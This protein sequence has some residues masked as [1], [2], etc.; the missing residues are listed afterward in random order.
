MKTRFYYL[1]LPLLGILLPAVVVGIFVNKTRIL[2]HY[3]NDYPF[4]TQILGA[5]EIHTH[6]EEKDSPPAE[7]STPAKKPGGHDHASE[8]EFSYKALQNIGVTKETIQ[9]TTVGEFPLTMNYPASV[10]ERPGRSTTN[11]TTPVSGIVLRIY[12]QPGEI[13]FP[14]EPM[15]DMDLSNESVITQQMDLI[16][17]CQKRDILEQ[18]LKRLGDV[19][20]G[21]V[22][23]T[24]R[25]TEFEKRQVE[26]GIQSLVNTLTLSGF[27]EE[28]IRRKI[29]D[30]RT[31]IRHVTIPVPTVDDDRL[32]TLNTLRV[33][34]DTP[35][36]DVHH[37]EDSVEKHA[38]LPE[39]HCEECHTE[40]QKHL[41][42]V[43][44]FVE[45]GQ[46]VTAGES[47]CRISDMSRLFLCGRAWDYD[48]SVLMESLMKK[49]PVS[50]VFQSHGSENAPANV[51]TGLHI[52][53]VDNRI[54][55]NSRTLNFYVEIQNELLDSACDHSAC[56]ERLLAQIPPET[57]T[58]ISVSEKT[59][60]VKPVSGGVPSADVRPMDE[61]RTL[62]WRY[63]PGQR[64]ELMIQY[65]T[66]PDCVLLPREAVAASGLEHF[67]FRM[68]HDYK[69][70]YSLLPISVRVLHQ[71][72][73]L[74]AVA[75]DGSISKNAKIAMRGAS[76]LVVA[77]SAARGGGA[78]ES[79]CGHDHSQ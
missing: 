31:L 73:N 9:K 8:L 53:F 24:I 5:T 15:L 37:A 43:Q 1:F 58:K 59:P 32:C 23:K 64:C 13:L 77:M 63:R 40:N 65:D 75:N 22:T 18:E 28:N 54:D 69:D 70:A 45:K 78:P 30:E 4:L 34:E 50:A 62:H 27:S 6:D 10:V 44:L 60:S 21:L 16:S 11:V 79:A 39:E 74:V 17:L 61:N 3:G 56:Q 67:V 72:R 46:R 26:S 68:V 38:A 19:A 35:H 55:V 20:E 57:V 51:V 25:E 36:G 14:G 66:I 48:E 7:P 76:Q 41:Q 29:I 49:A 2:E 42:L 52:K 12:R 47:L 33:R 71:S